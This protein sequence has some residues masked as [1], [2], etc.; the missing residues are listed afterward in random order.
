M[1]FKSQM[2]TTLLILALIFSCAVLN[3]Q[4]IKSPG[5]R[6]I[7][8]KYDGGKLVWRV[9]A[10]PSP[11]GGAFLSLRFTDYNYKNPK[12]GDSR[13]VMVDARE[14][15]PFSDMLMKFSDWSDR[16]RLDKAP[17]FSKIMPHKVRGDW[18]LFWDGS[19][20]VLRSEKGDEIQERDAKAYRALLLLAVEMLSESLK[21]EHE[22][23]AY[24]DSLK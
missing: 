6:E 20:A 21:V 24:A 5:A 7:A 22:A 13:S 15:L 4:V 10:W 14:Y 23:R 12:A 3:A 2:K 18:M 8:E 1:P 19:A 17:R 16:A 11:G 9:G